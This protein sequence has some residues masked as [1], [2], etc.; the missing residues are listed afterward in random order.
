MHIARHIYIYI[1]TSGMQSIV[2]ERESAHAK[3]EAH[4]ALRYEQC[5]INIYIYVYVYRYIEKIARSHHIIKKAR[6]A[7]Q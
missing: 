2:G 6:Y 7:R 1:Y 5:R 4:T 3:L